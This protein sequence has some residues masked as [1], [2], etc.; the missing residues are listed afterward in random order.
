M[1]KISGRLGFKDGWFSETEAMW[2][3]Q[4]F[5]LALEVGNEG[6]V[7]KFMTG[8]SEEKSV[9]FAEKSDFQSIVVF[10]SAQYGEKAERLMNETGMN[11]NS[12]SQTF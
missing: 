11:R 1:A 10:R 4:K 2:P 3:G 8:F 9:L 7:Q 5:S 12:L 6:A